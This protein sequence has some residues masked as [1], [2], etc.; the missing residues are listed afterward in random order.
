MP[1]AGRNQEFGLWFASVDAAGSVWRSC[2][3]ESLL[4]K[5][6][7]SITSSKP[8]RVLMIGPRMKM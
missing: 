6:T 8:A 5:K 3:P 4:Q 7:R 1:Q 2:L